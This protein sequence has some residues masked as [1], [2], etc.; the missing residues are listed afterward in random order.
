MVV[1]LT[2]TA[3]ID[4]GPFEIYSNATGTFVLVESGISRAQLVAGYICYI[5]P[6]GTTIV[7]VKS[8]GSCTNFADDTLLFPTPTPTIMP[9]PTPIPEIPCYGFLYNWYAATDSRNIA[10]NGWHIPTAAELTNLI[11]LAGGTYPAGEKLKETGTLHWLTNNGTNEYQFNA[12]GGGGRLSSNGT[13]NSLKQMVSFWGS[14]TTVPDFAV[15][16]VLSDGGP[17]FNVPVSG[18]YPMKAGFSIRLIKDSTTL[19]EGDVGTYT[20]NDGKTYATICIG[21]GASK[22]EWV[23]EN[24]KE[25]KF[26]DGSS[27]PEVTSDLLWIG[28][29]TGAFC[30]YNNNWE[31]VCATPPPTPTPATIY[32]HLGTADNYTTASAACLQPNSRPYFTLA[33][34]ALYNGIRVY[35][36][37]SC[38]V[39]FV[40]AGPGHFYK[41]QV[42]EGGSAYKAFEISST[43]YILTTTDC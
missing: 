18:G 33:Y 6:D 28:L 42:T 11:T 15:A 12:R 43:G 37:S 21:T 36:D 24:L 3:G 23:S 19:N 40:G 22:Q 30:A 29:T 1:L 25:T 16:G 34:P 9:T 5:M 10:S 26:R 7:R 14:T 4:T 41:I 2:I 38:I 17:V 35:D 31:N 13:F 39:P 8:T 27:I 20:G 32:T